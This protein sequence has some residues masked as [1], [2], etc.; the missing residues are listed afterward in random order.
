MGS[1]GNWWPLA[2]FSSVA[3][4]GCF[5]IFVTICLKISFTSCFV[6]FSASTAAGPWECAEQEP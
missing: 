2:V 5:G 3:P 6:A 1:F 4:T